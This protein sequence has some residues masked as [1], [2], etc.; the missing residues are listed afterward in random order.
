VRTQPKKKTKKES[1]SNNNNN[2]RSNSSSHSHSSSHRHKR[3]RNK[4]RKTDSYYTTL[5][6]HNIPFSSP[7]LLPLL[8]YL[9]KVFQGFFL[10]KK[11]NF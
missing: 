7:L 1:S 6:L 5:A 10:I 11:F 8:T 3:E 9:L 4:E 2:N